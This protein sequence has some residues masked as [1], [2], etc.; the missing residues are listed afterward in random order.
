M[1][2]LMK[3]N[4]YLIVW[5][6]VA[7][8]HLR[9]FELHHYDNKLLNYFY[10]MVLMSVCVCTFSW[11]LILPACNQCLSPLKLWVWVPFMAGVLDTTLCDKVCQWL[12][13]GRRFFAGTPISSTNKTDCHDI[14]EILLKVA[15]NTI[16]LY[17]NLIDRTV[18][19]SLHSN[20]SS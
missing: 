2:F 10:E 5:A 4:Q 15:L 13:A 20:M 9:V 17:C 14:A 19:L 7:L 18:H 8:H 11:I 12:E 16:N 3:Y 1:G 6:I